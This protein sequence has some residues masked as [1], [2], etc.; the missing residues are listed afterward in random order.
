MPEMEGFTKKGAAQVLL[1]LATGA[2]GE[3][4]QSQVEGWAALTHGDW[5]GFATKVIPRVFRDVAKGASIATEGIKDSRGNVILPPDKVGVSGG[6]AQAFGFQP[7][8]VSEFREGRAAVQQATQEAKDEHTRLTQKW[9]KA[10][11]ED[12]AD[13]MDEIHDYNADPLHAGSRITMSQLL[14]AKQAQRKQGQMP[15]GL[16]LP[17]KGMAALA[18][19]GRFANVQ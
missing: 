17:R 13:I 9:L 8:T 7:S 2:T 16:K 5:Q 15:F 19:E 10:D 6:I 18:A 1:G 14:Q 11:P 3:N 4:L 12:R